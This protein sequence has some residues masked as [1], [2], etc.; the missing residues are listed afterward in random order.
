MRPPVEKG[1]T[2][3]ELR[4]LR[5]LFSIRHH[6]CVPVTPRSEPKQPGFDGLGIV[7]RP[8]LLSGEGRPNL[9]AGHLLVATMAAV[10]S[11]NRRKKKR[12]P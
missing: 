4:R 9:P 7:V 6:I 12:C 3:S 2:L 1:K 8:G 5:R 11:Q 10:G